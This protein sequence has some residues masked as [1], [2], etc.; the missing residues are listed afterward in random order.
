MCVCII[1]MAY[2]WGD[3]SFFEYYLGCTVCS[4]VTVSQST[5]IRG[6]TPAHYYKIT[7]YIIIIIIIENELLVTTLYSL[8]LR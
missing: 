6:Y 2:C 5:A 8:S 7:H 4:D 3:R 1:Q